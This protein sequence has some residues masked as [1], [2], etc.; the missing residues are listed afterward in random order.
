MDGTREHSAVE[1]RDEAVNYW[2]T[3]LS[4]V[5]HALVPLFAESCG[6][7]RSLVTEEQGKISEHRVLTSELR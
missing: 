6:G 5:N 3:T 2:A 4:H 1:D 7:K